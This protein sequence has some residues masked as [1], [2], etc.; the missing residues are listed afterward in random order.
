MS[1]NRPRR[2]P[3]CPRLL[4]PKPS[5]KPRHPPLIK[6]GIAGTEGVLAH[7]KVKV[8]A[9]RGRARAHHPVD[10]LAPALRLRLLL[11]LLAALLLLHHVGIRQGHVTSTSVRRG[12]WSTNV[13]REKIA[14]TS[15]RKCP[16]PSSRPRSLRLGALRRIRLQ[17][18]RREHAP[19]PRDRAKVLIT[20][21]SVASNS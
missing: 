10:H 13:Q 5:L 21:S 6:T 15:T 18:P 7:P 9:K 12:A 3:A 1:A 11:P 19:H 14:P 16:T 17:P 8:V 4:S 2:L 20:P